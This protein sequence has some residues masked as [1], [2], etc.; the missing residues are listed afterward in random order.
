MFEIK[1]KITRFVD[2]AQPG[3]VE[4]EVTD[5][6]GVTRQCIDKLPIFTAAS[7]NANSDYLS[8]AH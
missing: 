5:A 1:V 7:L 8:M 3:M 4:C 2:D 6:L